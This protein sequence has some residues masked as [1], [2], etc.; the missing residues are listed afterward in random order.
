MDIQKTLF[1]FL[2]IL[3]INEL[4]ELGSKLRNLSYYDI[5][6]LRVIAFQEKCTITLLS[7]KLKKTKPRLTVK[8]KV[9][10]KCGYLIK[11]S[12]Y[13]DRRVVYINVNPNIEET[14]EKKSKNIIHLLK[15]IEKGKTKEQLTSFCEI[16]NLISKGL[17]SYD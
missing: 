1:H 15:K 11:E 10:E 16:L 9:L 6:L 14:M 7:K 4:R 17:E 2:D 8:V 3:S 5:L 12:S 13:D